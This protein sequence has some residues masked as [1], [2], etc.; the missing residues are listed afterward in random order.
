MANGLDFRFL[1]VSLGLGPQALHVGDDLCPFAKPCFYMPCKS[2]QK[3]LVPGCRRG[4]EA[5][6]GSRQASKGPPHPPRRSRST[7]VHFKP[8]VTVVRLCRT[9]SSTPSHRVDACC[10]C[11]KHDVPGTYGRDFIVP[12]PWHAVSLRHRQSNH[13]EANGLDH[14]TV[15]QT[16]YSL[17]EALKIRMMQPK[18]QTNKK[19]PKKRFY[20]FFQSLRVR[21]AWV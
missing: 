16:S 18:K 6:L 14:A 21:G 1:Q 7:G 19:N 9:G 11:L 10:L 20:Y 3:A 4:R 5:L 12:S 13:S 8:T 2:T 17:C 15:R